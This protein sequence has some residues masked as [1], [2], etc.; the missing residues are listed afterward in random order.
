MSASLT[1]KLSRVDTPLGVMLVAT[2]A[3]GRLR[4]LDWENY[5]PR[6]RRLIDRLYGKGAV[7]LVEGDGK[8]P[9]FVK[10]AAFFAGDLRAIDDIPVETG[11]TAFQRDVW[12]ALRS[13]PCRRDPQLRPTGQGHRPAGCG[14]RRGPGHRV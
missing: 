10:L 5:E 14:S 2:D 9:V 8:G 1:F 13:I 12:A 6:M 7:T 4:I 11:G 3:E